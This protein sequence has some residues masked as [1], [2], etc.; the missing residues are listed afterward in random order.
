MNNKFQTS[1][2][3]LAAF[4]KVRNVQLLEITPV[5]TW[6]SKF[7]FEKPPQEYLE[8]WLSGEALADVRQTIN[9]YRHPI[10]EAKAA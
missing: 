1:D 5:T 3:T 8:A 2:V 9:C 4:L 7:I 6:A 10:S